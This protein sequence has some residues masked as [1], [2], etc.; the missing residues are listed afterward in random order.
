VK[1]PNSRTSRMFPDNKL[2]YSQLQDLRSIQSLPD[3]SIYRA[4]KNVSFETSRRRNG[5][6]PS[7]SSYSL[8]SK[9]RSVSGKTKKY[10]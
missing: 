3:S 4:E 9:S 10:N 6:H 2:D 1:L 5:N 8:S 7:K